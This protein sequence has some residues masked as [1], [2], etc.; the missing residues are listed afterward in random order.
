MEGWGEA[1]TVGIATATVMAIFPKIADIFASAFATITDA[2]KQSTDSS[3]DDREWYLGINDAAGYGEPATIM[4][5]LLLIPII[6]VLSIVL[7]GNQALPLVDLV[8]LPYLVQAI[9]SVSNGNIFKSLITG[10]VYLV[11]GLYLV[12]MVAPIFT[13]VALEVGVAIPDGALMIFSLTV[14]TNLLGGILF[15]VFMTQNGWLIALTVFVYLLMFIIFKKNKQAFH[16]YLEKQA[17]GN[18]LEQ[19]VNTDVSSE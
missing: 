6:V 18:E 19:P 1:F 4:T 5:G 10:T 13:E 17:L 12:T 16:T 3:D 8:A 9:V 7:P 15:L 11:M 14:L 2:S